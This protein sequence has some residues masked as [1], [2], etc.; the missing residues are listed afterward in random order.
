MGYGTINFHGHIYEITKK[1]EKRHYR[2]LDLLFAD[3]LVR[4]VAGGYGTEFVF[5]GRVEVYHN[6]QWGTVCGHSYL[7]WGTRNGDV[8]CKQLGYLRALHSTA[9]YFPQGTGQIWISEVHC[10]GNETN[11]VQCEFPGW[12]V[13]PNYCSHYQDVGVFCARE[14]NV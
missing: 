12:G 6:N 11:L 4:L 14:S 13:H 7:D 5:G 10:V 2:M 9:H 1:L 3:V 8:V